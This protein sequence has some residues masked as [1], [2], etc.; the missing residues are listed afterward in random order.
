[1]SHL[2]GLQRRWRCPK[3]HEKCCQAYQWEETA[4][5]KHWEDCPL[6]ELHR[7]L[8]GGV[9]QRRATSSKRGKSYSQL[10]VFLQ[11]EDVLS[12][13]SE[14]IFSG[15]LTKLSQ[16]QN[17]S[18]Q[19]MFF[20]FDHQMI[21]CKKVLQCFLF[22]WWLWIVSGV[23]KVQKSSWLTRQHWLIFF[24]SYG[25][26]RGQSS[27]AH[28]GRYCTLMLES[29]S[30]IPTEGCVALKQTAHGWST[31]GPCVIDN[32]HKHMRTNIS[33]LQQMNG[34]W[35]PQLVFW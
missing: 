4:P 21:Y 34:W 24:L 7:G 13:S 17:K 29:A 23:E 6:A 25:N 18:Q 19:R 35:M 30:T 10:C 9:R 3:C 22:H 31:E 8:G 15:E 26:Q 2:Q 20:L 11:G 28:W 14:L 32:R 12:R 5:W 33:K 1:M 27:D 16:P